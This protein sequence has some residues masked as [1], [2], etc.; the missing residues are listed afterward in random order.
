MSQTKPRAW[1]ICYD[2]ADR[3]RLGR[4][5]RFLKKHAQPVQYSVFHFEGS[6]AQLGRLMQDIKTYIKPKEDD[7][8]AYPIPEKVQLYTLGRGVLPDNLHLESSRSP[9]LARLVRPGE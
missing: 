1:L 6:S 4:L 8:R 5:H 2:I 9:G 3:G 7:V